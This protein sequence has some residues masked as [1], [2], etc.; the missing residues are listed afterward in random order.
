[1][2]TEKKYEN[3]VRT[4]GRIE[5]KI[6]REQFQKVCWDLFQ[7]NMESTDGN[8]EEAMKRCWMQIRYS[9]TNYAEEFGYK[10]E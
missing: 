2:S 1:M 10:F 9:A 8:E 6:Y 5:P 3:V 7:K 4:S